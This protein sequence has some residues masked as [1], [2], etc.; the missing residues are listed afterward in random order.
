MS[1]LGLCGV[2]SSS[3]SFEPVVTAIDLPLRS[4]DVIAEPEGNS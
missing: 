4:G 3:F 1:L 2:I